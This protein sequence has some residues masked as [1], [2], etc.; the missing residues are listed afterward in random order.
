MKKDVSIPARLLKP[1][2]NDAEKA[3]LS[4]YGEQLCTDEEIQQRQK[5]DAE[6]IV[7][8]AQREKDR[9][10]QTIKAALDEIDAKTIRPIREGDAKRLAEL[11][12]QAEAL[13]KEL[14]GVR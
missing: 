4:K 7:I 11:N 5:D 10:I 13:R 3:E 1:Y 9:K 6:H 2:L 14:A 12:A 8:I